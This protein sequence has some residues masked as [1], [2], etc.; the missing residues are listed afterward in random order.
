MEV[1][2]L[3]ELREFNELDLI[4]KIIE[5]AEGNKKRAEQ[6][7]RGNKTAGV[8]IRHSMQDIRLLAEL[9]RESIQLN[10]GT[11]KVKMGEYKGE[12]IPLTK[13]EKAIIDKKESLEKEEVYIKRAEN[14]RKKKREELNNG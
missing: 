6:F 8:D 13:L 5:V 1:N 14:L 7:L 4:F 11:R 10:K 9:I 3:E 12:F 2:E